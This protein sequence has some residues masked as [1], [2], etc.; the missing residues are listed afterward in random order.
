MSGNR[1]HRRR[2]NRKKDGHSFD[3]KKTLSLS[4][5]LT[6]ALS[7]SLSLSYTH[8]LTHSQTHAR[9]CGGELALVWVFPDCWKLQLLNESFIS[10]I[11][12]LPKFNIS[13]YLKIYHP[14]NQETKKI[15]HGFNTHIHTHT[16]TLSHT[17]THTHALKHL[18]TH[19]HALRHSHTLTHTLIHTHAQKLKCN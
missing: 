19:T 6:H 17:R 16:H 7:L 2:P 8:T 9:T 4:L 18:H 3:I 13:G 5:S 14:E 15:E 10:A 11:P 1:R 12:I